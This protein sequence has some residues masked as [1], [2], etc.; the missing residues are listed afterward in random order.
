VLR[1]ARPTDLLMATMVA[2]ILVAHLGTRGH[3]LH[4]FGPRYYFE[5]F[6]LLFLLTARGFA[7][8]ARMGR[9][10]DLTEKKTP[11]LAAVILFLALNFSAAAFLPRR[12]GLYRAYN[13]VDSSLQQQVEEARLDRALI[14][15]P[16]ADWRG[17]AMAARLMEPG[18]DADLLFI[19]TPPDDPAIPKIAGGRP[20]FFWRDG[21]LTPE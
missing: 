3:G 4:G 1:R 13:G 17:W 12:L 15:L 19:Q 5:A 20:V 18:A 10:V 11:A 21:R 16:V 7:E 2:C 9:G 6:A 8:L 14:V